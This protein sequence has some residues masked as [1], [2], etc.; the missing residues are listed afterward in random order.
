MLRY[1]PEKG[2]KFAYSF[3][4]DGTITQTVMGVEQTINLNTKM[5][6]HYLV[7]NIASNGNVEL[8]ISVDTIETRMKTQVLQMDTT[9]ILPVGFKFRQ[10]IDKFGRGVSFEILEIKQQRLLSGF[11]ENLDKRQYT[12]AVIFPERKIKPNDSWNFS[13]ADTTISDEGQA[14]VKT[15]GKYTF[16]GIETVNQIRCARLKVDANF[17]ISGQGTIQGM[18]YGLEGEGKNVGTLWV[19]LGTG[20]VVRSDTNAE[21]ETAMGIKGQIEMTLPMSQRM[22]TVLNL[23][24]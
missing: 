2:K 15:S 12:H 1:Q 22:R 24:R 20:I 9:L 19:D 13:Y 5:T 3:S 6:I 11:G 16:E 4:T 7:Q 8:I 23:I 17:A 21:I 14:I 10:V 18:K